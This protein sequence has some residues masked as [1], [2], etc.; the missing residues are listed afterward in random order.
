MD[1][2]KYLIEAIDKRIEI[3]LKNSKFEHS[4]T[5]RVVSIADDRNSAMVDI[6][7]E[8]KSCKMNATSNVSEND[9]VRVIYLQNDTKRAWIDGGSTSQINKDSIKNIVKEVLQEMGY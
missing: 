4:D 3:A 2:C 8:V 5:G 6:R 7:G 1:S 9:I